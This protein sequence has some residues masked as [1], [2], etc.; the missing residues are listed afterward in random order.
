MRLL[1]ATILQLQQLQTRNTAPTSSQVSNDVTTDDATQPERLSLR[2]QT[3]QEL[4]GLKRV[5]MTSLSTNMALF[6]RLSER[7]DDAV[8]RVEEEQARRKSKVR[9]CAV[10]LAS[11]NSIAASC[12]CRRS[13]L[14]PSR[15]LHARD[16]PRRRRRPNRFAA[17]RSRS[18]RSCGRCNTGQRSH[19]ICLS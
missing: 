4:A 19:V 11:L 16:T 14:A 1:S 9:A 13:C 8:R 2:E 3:Q 7:T 18:G 15:C 12:F 17:R 5:T 10:A 6:E